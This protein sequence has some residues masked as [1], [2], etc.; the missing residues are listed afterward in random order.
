[1]SPLPNANKTHTNNP[2]HHLD[3]AM[4]QLFAVLYSKIEQASSLSVLKFFLS[5]ESLDVVS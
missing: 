1:M 3:D 2:N 4:L 5:I